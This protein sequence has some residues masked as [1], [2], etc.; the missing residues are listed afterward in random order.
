[1]PS[2]FPLTLVCVLPCSFSLLSSNVVSSNP[3]EE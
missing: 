3:K 2:A 1:L